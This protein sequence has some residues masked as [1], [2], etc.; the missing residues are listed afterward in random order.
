[1]AVNMK[2][3]VI[4][5][6]GMFLVLGAIL[7]AAAGTLAWAGGWAFLLLFFVFTAAISAWLVQH[8]P[9][10]LTERLGGTIRADQ[11]PWDRTMTILLNLVFLAWLIVMPL[12]AVRF[13]WSH[14]PGWLQVVGAGLLLL[15]FYGFFLTFRANAYLSPVVRIQEERQHSV[16]TTG[17]YRIIRHP[18]Y[19]SVIPFAV[20]ASLLMG[21]YLGLVPAALLMLAVARRAVLEEQ[22]LRDELPGYREYIQRTRYRLIPGVW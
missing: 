4:Q 15:S 2:N 12:D 20:G 21:S 9:A 6:G 19:A 18:M 3:L 1:M 14:V 16:I 11:R 22:T 7:F 5:V 8:S 10:L 13:G 17:P